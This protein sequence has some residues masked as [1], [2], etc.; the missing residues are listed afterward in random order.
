MLNRMRLLGG[1]P[2]KHI[3]YRFEK[4][5]RNKLLGAEWWNLDKDEIEKAMILFSIKM[6][7]RR[8]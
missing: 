1:V 3:R 6:G 7:E 5:I 2:A 8:P 4:D